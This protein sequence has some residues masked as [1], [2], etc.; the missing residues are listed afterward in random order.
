MNG[1]LRGLVLWY[2]ATKRFPNDGFSLHNEL[3]H[4]ALS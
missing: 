2:W 1:K 3:R 4:M